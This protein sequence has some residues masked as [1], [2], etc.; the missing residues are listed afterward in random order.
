M[1]LKRENNFRGVRDQGRLF[2]FAAAAAS[3]RSLS[4][5]IGEQHLPVA[6]TTLLVAVHVGGKSVK[7]VQ[8]VFS[9]FYVFPQIY[10][11]RS[12]T[13]FLVLG[14]LPGT[15]F[16]MTQNGCNFEFHPIQWSML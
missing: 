8:A 1:R 2:E 15:D 12:Q 4:S 7:I 5:F 13:D 10:E 11:A 6:R 3:A 9:W 16:Q 14:F